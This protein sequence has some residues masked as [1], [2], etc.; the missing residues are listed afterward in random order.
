MFILHYI[1]EYVGNLCSPC[2][3]HVQPKGEFIIASSVQDFCICSIQ[4]LYRKREILA[5]ENFG[6][7]GILLKFAK[8]NPP[9][10]KNIII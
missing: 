7:F 1:K 10:F 2:L 6:E 8:F 9:I 5:E 3:L 4:L